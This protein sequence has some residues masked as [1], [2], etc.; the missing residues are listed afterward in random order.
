MAGTLVVLTGAS[1]VGKTAIAL[2]VERS[3][4][5]YDVFDST[6]LVCPQP[7]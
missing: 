3:H 7:R 6:A 1:G 2:D 5:D 4:P